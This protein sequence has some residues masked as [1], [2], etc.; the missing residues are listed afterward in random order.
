MRFLIK[1]SFLFFI[2][3]SCSPIKS[4]PEGEKHQMEL[5]LHE[6][7]TNI[8]DMQHDVYCF[9]AEIQ[10]L[11]KK[12]EEL[13]KLKT[14][15][16]KLKNLEEVIENL[17]VRQEKILL[18][19]KKFLN[20]SDEIR[21]VLV[22]YKDKIERIENVFISQNKKF[23]R[24]DELKKALESVVD[25]INDRYYIYIVKPGD[26]LVSIAKEYKVHVSEIKKEN[27]IKGELIIV[28]QELKIP[29]K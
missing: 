7:N 16:F 2:I 12:L 1:S 3:Y 6:L 9:K 20:F 23:K 17:K 29:K 18:D 4:S 27:R 26:S 10:I 11:E 28:G 21:E 8:D 13:E 22:Q 14:E 15:D 25:S 5:T 24:I 19:L